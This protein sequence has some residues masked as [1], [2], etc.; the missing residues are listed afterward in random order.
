MRRRRRRAFTLI[1]AM[2]ALA[3]LAILL[4]VATLAPEAPLREA[5]DVVVRARAIEWLDYE[6]DALVRGVPVD[7]EIRAALQALVPGG[8]VLVERRASTRVVLVRWRHPD[9]RAAF[10]ERVALVNP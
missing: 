2:V 8:E 5:G 10:L 1:E 9:G 7:R 4:S 3:M 6:V